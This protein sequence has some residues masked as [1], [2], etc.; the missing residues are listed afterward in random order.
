MDSVALNHIAMKHAN[1]EPIIDQA[2]TDDDCDLIKG[3]WPVRPHC[4]LVDELVIRGL[5]SPKFRRRG[6][7]PHQ[8][9]PEA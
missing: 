3:Q 2:I 6:D 4:F 9:G 1:G 5:L 7:L 8:Q